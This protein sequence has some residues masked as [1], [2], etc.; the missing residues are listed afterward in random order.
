MYV[1]QA[2]QTHLCF[3]LCVTSCLM[4]SA[5]DSPTPCT[6]VTYCRTI[7]W[8]WEESNPRLALWHKDLRV[9]VTKL[10]PLFCSVKIVSVDWFSPWRPR[11]HSLQ[12]SVT[13]HFQ[14]WLQYARIGGSCWKIIKCECQVVTWSEVAFNYRDDDK[15]QVVSSAL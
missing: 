5:I 3:K 14:I 4:S 10:W 15:L 6:K 9:I 8:R 2:I 1:F 12:T 11:P 13:S 7:S